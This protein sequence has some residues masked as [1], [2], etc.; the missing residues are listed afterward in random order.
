MEFSSIKTKLALDLMEEI[1]EQIQTIKDIRSDIAI[2]MRKK[3]DRMKNL[4]PIGSDGTALRITEKINEME[5]C[6]TGCAL[7][8]QLLEK[9]L[10]DL[11]DQIVNQSFD[12]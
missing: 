3:K 6:D 8:I 2:D 7:H 5:D 10:A 12:L 4:D 9:S 1:Q 11:K